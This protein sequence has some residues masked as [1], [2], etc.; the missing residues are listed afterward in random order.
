MGHFGIFRSGDTHN[1]IHE[2][3]FAFII[4]TAAVG[5]LSQLWRPKENVAGQLVALIAWGAMVVAALITG[6][7]VPQP[8][9]IIFGGPTLIATILHPAGRGLFSWSSASRINK[10]LFILIVVAA[11]PFLVFAFANISQQRSGAMSPGESGEM[12]NFFGH[13]IPQHGGNG[14]T[15]PA[16]TEAVKRKYGNY[17][18]AQAERE[19][20]KLDTFCLDAESFGQ[21]KELGAMG[22]HAT[23]ESLLRG[24][25]S[26][27]R[28]QALMFDEK[29]QILGVEYEI[30]TDAV[31]EPPQ[32]FGQT[33]KKLPPHPGVNHEHYAL[34]VWFSDN[35]NGEFAD[36]NANVICPPGS[37][38]TAGS[39]NLDAMGVEGE[40]GHDMEH[41]AAGHYRNMAAYS[42]IVILVGL[43]ASFRPGGWRFAAW[44]AGLLS[45]LLGLVSAVL[46][47]A[48]SSLG[49]AWGIA[50]AVW[51]IVFIVAAE[52]TR[53]T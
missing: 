15:E 5:L 23:N 16:S 21:P 4:G 3:A 19:G 28:P 47:S 14:A 37:T 27:D 51:G 1:L 29:G 46:P 24:P 17:T 52:L 30:M 42:L 34:H 39:G 45:I 50:A 53:K 49:I 7:W 36:F 32:L 18:V 26:T 40:A 44:I 13:K 33:F 48:E 35:P 25:I 12:F 20:Y 41:V 43:L 11:V 6:N 22:Y 2:L 31:S 10:T 38:P 8:L 9:F